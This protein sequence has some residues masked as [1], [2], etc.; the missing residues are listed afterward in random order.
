M[1][2][3]FFRTKFNLN[4]LSAAIETEGSG[5][6]EF[7]RL[8]QSYLHQRHYT[9]SRQA[10][11]NLVYSMFNIGFVALPIVAKCLGMPLF[12]GIIL[13]LSVATAYTSVITVKIANE[14]DLRTMEDLAEFAFGAKGFYFTCYFQMIFSICL[15]CIT[16]N[17]WCDIM[18]DIVSYS[19]NATWNNN[20]ALSD[21]QLRVIFVFV[22][23][24]LVFP[25]SF[26]VK[27]IASLKWISFCV[28]I[29]LLIAICSLFIVLGVDTNIDVFDLS[30][31]QNQEVVLIKPYWWI[32]PVILTFVFSYIHK[33][34]L[35]Y[36]GI[37]QRSPKKWK[38][39]VFRSHI[40]V[41]ITFIVFGIVGYLSVLLNT[42]P[43]DLYA[44]SNYFTLFPDDLDHQVAADTFR[45]IIAFCLLM[46]VPLESLVV[47]NSITRLYRRYFPI[48]GD[49]SCMGCMKQN[50]CCCLTPGYYDEDEDEEDGVEE[51]EEEGAEPL[52]PHGRN[53]SDDSSIP[54][55]NDTGD[56][57]RDLLLAAT[58]TPSHVDHSDTVVHEKE[59]STVHSLDLPS[60][61]AIESSRQS[62]VS[63]TGQN[64]ASYQLSAQSSRHLSD[65]DYQQHIL[66]EA[67]T[68]SPT[69]R[70]RSQ[71]SQSS[72]QSKLHSVGTEE[73]ITPHHSVAHDDTS[74]TAVDRIMAAVYK[75]PKSAALKNHPENDAFQWRT[76][77]S[78]VRQN[79][80][81]LRGNYS[82]STQESF[83]S[84]FGLPTA[85]TNSSS[86]AIVSETGRSRGMSS[87]S[88]AAPGLKAPLLR[89]QGAGSSSGALGSSVLGASN[90][91]ANASE[92]EARAYVSRMR[93]LSEASNGNR[94]G[95]SSFRSLLRSPVNI[96]HMDS[97]HGL[98]RPDS[99]AITNGT[100]QVEDEDENNEDEDFTRSL[101]M[102]YIMN[103][104]VPCFS[105][106]RITVA[107]LWVFSIST[108]LLYYLIGM[109]FMM[110]VPLSS[111][112]V[113]FIIPG[114]VYFKLGLT[115]DYQSIPAL[116]SLVNNK[117][118][119]FVVIIL[120]YSLAIA[121]IGISIYA[122]M[123]KGRVVV[124]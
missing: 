21:L 82:L 39:V 58:E 51:G 101:S 47:V 4:N 48:D 20:I 61:P 8:V 72:Q 102:G 65:S 2:A 54:S 88:G 14:Y 57:S 78:P 59:S 49:N 95:N 90:T 56:T 107:C 122:F 6:T 43:D 28:V 85:S 124:I 9:S 70:Q 22:G 36:G 11:F 46:T 3:Y 86:G 100:Q 103:R 50:L 16:L 25:L 76:L 40:L 117:L 69:L 63:Q 113:L 92:N 30:D 53:T 81:K 75:R 91:N 96:S 34:F 41:T 68:A 73:T 120:G 118:R 44:K 29:L 106:E 77:A 62:L 111:A 98:R 79:K 99:R 52:K 89:G 7:E 31:E 97:T 23:S 27:A 1:F 67:T 121:N 119:M 94:S 42:S 112:V 19:Q 110:I 24:L 104:R 60:E 38:T 45:G 93:F 87:Q 105:I 55:M 17:T 74:L 66:L 26:R 109:G 115:S 116:F 83:L 32:F 13:V 64:S 123:V 71:D 37:R 18:L 84:F 10:F 108:S 5:G 12:V 35:V 80:A 114:H 33:I 15:I